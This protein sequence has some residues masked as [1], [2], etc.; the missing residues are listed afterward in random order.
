[1][2]KLF[3]F[4]LFV[5][6]TLNQPSA[7]FAQDAAK[8]LQPSPAPAAVGL[9]HEE[10]AGAN[11]EAAR[12]VL[13]I[14][15]GLSVEVELA[16]AVSS[17][18]VRKDDRLSFRVVNPVRVNG[19]V[20]IVAGATATA[21]VVKAS[22]GGHFGRA[23]RLAWT[24]EDVFAVDGTRVPLRFDGRTVGD[25]K[26]AKVATQTV[27]TGVLLGPAA[28]LALLTGFKRGENANLPAGKRFAVNVGGDTDVS[29][30]AQPR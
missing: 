6:L 8:T 4:S 13:K 3:A 16:Y 7:S 5:C 10:A 25:S 21:R 29:V 27:L 28:P 24:M 11:A 14:P 30:S 26:G 9:L 22:R 12:R 23:G 19:V 18:E 20:V 2:K 15:A 1:M 17:Q